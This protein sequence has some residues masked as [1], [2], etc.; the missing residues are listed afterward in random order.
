MPTMYRLLLCWALTLPAFAQTTPA[1]EI[2]FDAQGLRQ[3]R[4]GG[5][6]YLKNGAFRVAA[7]TLQTDTGRAQFNGKQATRSVDVAARTVTHTFPWGSYQVAYTP[8]ADRLDV[9]IRVEN[10]SPHTLLTHH[11][12]VLDLQLPQ[13][14]REYDGKTPLLA[15]NTGGLS[16]QTLTTDA[17]QVVLVNKDVT[18]PLLMGY[19]WSANR[20][21][22]T[23]YPLWVL[24]GR[25]PWL[26]TSLP[27]IQRPVPPG[28]SDTYHLSLR[29]ADSGAPAEALTADVYAAFARAHP[30][31]LHWTDRR[32]IATLFLASA[33]LKIE[34]NPR[35]WFND[36]KN[37][38]VTTPQGL[39]A[40]G[41]RMLAYADKSIQ[42][43]REMG[44][45]GAITWD[46]EGQQYP[47]A[48]S[49]VGDPQKLGELAPEMEAVADAYFARFRT[50]GLRT[51]VT[52]RPQAF[53]FVEGRP[54][55]VVLKDG[56]G[57]IDTAAVRR[58]LDAKI[59]YARQRWGCT[60]FYIDSN[61]GP[62]D[63][64]P[65][66]IFQRLAAAHPDVLLMPEHETLAYF[67]CT[68]PL[69][70]LQHLN[71]TSTPDLARRVYPSAFTVNLA[72]DPKK[73]ESRRDPLVR[74][75]RAGDVLLFR[76]W[77]GDKA[78]P[79]IREVY[80]AAGR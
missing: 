78:N 39:A 69:I 25:H 38:D 9:D 72:A 40:F 18:R 59:T 55:Q 16:V 23:V 53:A 28:A 30:S 6:P 47:H 76:G 17:G 32:P 64:Y 1:V 50:A 24:T 45:Q 11:L 31:T 41:A 56:Q 4:Y 36:K 3:L 58:L 60:L 51:G 14:P 68:A 43:M 70:T 73:L 79:M 54:R 15:T 10:R 8:H 20:P 75:V 26:P 52:L 65:A 80:E 63:P 2:T 77:F 49:Y 19:P 71:Q 21:R 33:N 61:G 46:V 42:I 37:V 13:K 29:F 67:S 74:A 48:I 12:H 7:A 66:E 62:S 57:R 5:V 22:S 44:A 27:T 35:G 34:N